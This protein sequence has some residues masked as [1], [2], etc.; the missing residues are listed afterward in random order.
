MLVLCL[1]LTLLWEFVL[2]LH[3]LLGYWES[4]RRKVLLFISDESVLTLLFH[5]VLLEL[6]TRRIP[7]KDGG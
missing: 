2:R 1:V 3:Q 7:R 4:D 6:G 5:L